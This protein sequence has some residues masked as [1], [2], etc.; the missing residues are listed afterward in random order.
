MCVFVENANNLSSVCVMRNGLSS[1]SVC[2]QQTNVELIDIH[3]VLLLH[4]NSQSKKKSNHLFFLYKN[5]KK[6]VK[7]TFFQVNKREKLL[8]SGGD[9]NWV[10]LRRKTT[11]KTLTRVVTAINLKEA[12][13]KKEF[14]EYK[15]QFFQRHTHTHTQIA[16][17]L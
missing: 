6:N 1:L 2:L 16:H 17:K 4:N 13:E 14:S 15:L 5:R 12:A 3:C 8:S 9:E 7:L 10:T 11:R